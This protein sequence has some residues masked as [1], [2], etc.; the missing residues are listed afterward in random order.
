MIHRDLNPSNLLIGRDG[1]LKI[2]GFSLS[3]Y[4]RP[5]AP[6]KPSMPVRYTGNV[7]TLSYRAPEL[8]LGDRSYGRPVD[9]WSVGCIIAEL[10]TC[11][12]LMQGEC[13][14][15]TLEKI[16][17]LCGRITPQSWPGVDKLPGY[18]P[19]STTFWDR[20]NKL[21]EKLFT[22][23]KSATD[24][25][26]GCLVCNPADRLTAEKALSHKY[27]EDTYI[28]DLCF[29]CDSPSH[30]ADDEDIADFLS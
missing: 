8:L 20:P 18:I 29:L 4:E 23:C 14:Q 17:E 19:R 27:F 5:N 28:E 9:M 11:E 22:K 12:T 24:V 10:Y 1:K 30:S 25:I 7:G 26:A 3:R 6:L 16:L 15:E 21:R 2:C 13:E